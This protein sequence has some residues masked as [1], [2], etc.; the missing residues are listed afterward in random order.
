VERLWLTPKG[1]PLRNSLTKLIPAG[2]AALSDHCLCYVIVCC[3]RDHALS[4]DK[5]AGGVTGVQA[6]RAGI[7]VSSNGS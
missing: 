4:F 2:C 6:R 1:T 5:I 7:P 3:R